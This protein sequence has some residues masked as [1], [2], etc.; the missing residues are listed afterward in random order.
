MSRPWVRFLRDEDPASGVPDT[1]IEDMAL[2]VLREIPAQF[3]EALSNVV[4]VAEVERDG[5]PGLLG[6]YEGVPITKRPANPALVPPDRITLF[7]A[8]I[9]RQCA[10]RSEVRW[11]VRKVVLHEVGHLIGMSEDRLHELGWG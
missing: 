8:P 7:T 11:Q 10:T 6:L 9:R 1:D 5:R 2:E 4:V 3:A